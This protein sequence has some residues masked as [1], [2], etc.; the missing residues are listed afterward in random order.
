[1]ERKNLSGYRFYAKD[2]REYIVATGEE[3]SAVIYKELNNTDSPLYFCC[4]AKA[5]EGKLSGSYKVSFTVSEAEFFRVIDSFEN[6]NNKDEILSELKHRYYKIPK[7]FLSLV[8]E[9]YEKD[10]R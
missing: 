9:L 1:M 3:D 6:K 10:G 5:S 7:I 8:F 2:N 4:D